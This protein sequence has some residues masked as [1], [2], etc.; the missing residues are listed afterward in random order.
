MF[1][2]ASEAEGKS[3]QLAVNSWIWVCIWI[4]TK[5]INVTMLRESIGSIFWTGH[6]TM[7]QCK[8]ALDS[9]KMLDWH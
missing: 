5:L 8:D 4:Y 1:Y 9:E 3:E 6:L 2:K 7:T